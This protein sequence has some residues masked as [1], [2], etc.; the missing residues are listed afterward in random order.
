M[1]TRFYERHKILFWGLIAIIPLVI[2]VLGCILAPEIFWDGFL[3]KYFWGPIVSDLEGRPIEGITEGYNVVNTIIYALILALALLAMYKAFKRFRINMDIGLIVASI[4]FFLFGGVSRALEDAV[5]FRGGL[6]YWFISPLI[7]VLIATLFIFSGIFGYL[8]HKRTSDVKGR[9]L[10]YIVQVAII[11]VIYYSVTIIWSGNLAYTLPPYIPFFIALLSVFTLY[12]LASKE[13]DPL[14]SFILCTGL[15]VLLIAISYAI[16]FAF[17]PEWQR[18]FS[19]IEG[20]SPTL[21]PMEAII[22][23]GIAIVLSAMLWAVGKAA[24]SKLGVL[25]APTSFLMFLAH[26]LD[27]TATFRGIDLYGYGEKHVLPTLLIDLAG[28]AAVMLLFKFLLVLAIIILVDVL[29]R[30]DLKSYPGLANIMKF[31]VIFL[32]MAPGT[33]DLVRISLGV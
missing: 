30:E 26:F 8:A 19:L 33:R 2:L 11:L 17:D 12:V 1:L 23:P 16:S 4:P 7:Y 31:A 10:L 3:Y 27:G 9:T 24:P 20:H 15:L 25:A 28:S 29:F 13:K 18:I 6:G 5:L 22:I 32:G 21:R 14:R